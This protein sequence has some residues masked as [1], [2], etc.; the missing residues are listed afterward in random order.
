MYIYALL[1]RWICYAVN[2][3]RHYGCETEVLALDVLWISLYLLHGYSSV[4]FFVCSLFICLDE[5]TMFDC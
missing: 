3:H 5:A 4:D 2:Y 1:M